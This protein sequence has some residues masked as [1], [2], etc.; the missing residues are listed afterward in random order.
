MANPKIIF[1]DG[2]EINNW[3]KYKKFLI[4]LFHFLIQ[5]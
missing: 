4:F 3:E 5:M 1:K 2:D